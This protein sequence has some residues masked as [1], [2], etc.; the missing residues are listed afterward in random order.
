[1][2]RK[3]RCDGKSWKDFCFLGELNKALGSGGQKQHFNRLPIWLPIFVDPTN[4]FSH[5]LY[6]LGQQIS[7]PILSLSLMQPNLP[8]SART[9]TPRPHCSAPL[10]CPPARRPAPQCRTTS[11]LSVAWRPAPRHSSLLP[12]AV[13]YS[14]A[15][16]WCSPKP[17]SPVRCRSLEATSQP[18]QGPPYPCEPLWRASRHRRSFHCEDRWCVHLSKQIHGQEDRREDDM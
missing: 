13:P 16:R 18:P 6:L 17:C 4:F 5:Y 3:I 8:L 15:R 7:L 14:L 12:S 9:H 11:C 2:C 1:M 10:P